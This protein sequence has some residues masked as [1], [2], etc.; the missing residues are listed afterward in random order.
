MGR[1]RQRKDGGCFG[2]R[3]GCFVWGALEETAEVTHLS[4]LPRPGMETKRSRRRLRSIC[5]LA[6]SLVVLL[7]ADDPCLRTL[8]DLQ[9]D[10]GIR[11]L[12]ASRPSI[13]LV[14]KRCVR[15][16]RRGVV[17]YLPSYSRG[18]TH[19]NLKVSIAPTD[20]SSRKEPG[21]FSF[22][23]RLWMGSGRSSSVDRGEDI[24]PFTLY[25]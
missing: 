1:R 15:S 10:L 22:F 19:C 21:S 16:I 17:V 7:S 13:G 2:R 24:L 12:Y 11:H 23:I 14:N 6:V 18:S 3:C 4:F 20:C 8:F 5:C 9:F 25:P